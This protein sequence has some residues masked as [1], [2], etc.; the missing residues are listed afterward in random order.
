MLQYHSNTQ[1]RNEIIKISLT[2]I[3]HTLACGM[4]FT[5]K[6]MVRATKGPMVMQMGHVRSFDSVPFF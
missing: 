5:S 3:T 4:E 2:R 6:A 1:T